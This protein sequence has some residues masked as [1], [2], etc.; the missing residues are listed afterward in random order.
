ML[1]RAV[2]HA[3]KDP[4]AITGWIN[5]IT[6]LHRHKPAPSVR[7]SKPMPDI[8]ALMQIWPPNFEEML[9]NTR[10]PDAELAVEL[11]D[12]VRLMCAIL[13]I[14]VYNNITESLHVLFSLYSDFKANVHFQQQLANEQQ[15]T[16][17]MGGGGYEGYDEGMAAEVS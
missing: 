13:D 11:R 17:T 1:V 2:E 9:E 6:D 5:S 10:L 8:E 14:P 7:Y 15:Q 16:I 12:L 4:K 3:E